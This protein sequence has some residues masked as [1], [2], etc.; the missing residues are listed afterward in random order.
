MSR[1]ILIILALCLSLSACSS[2][3]SAIDPDGDGD[4][5]GINY[6]AKSRP[7]SGKKVFIFDPNYHAWAAYDRSGKLVNTGKASGGA[8][9]CIDIKQSCHTVTGKFRILF[10]KGEDCV[11]KT[12]P[13]ETKGGA[14]MPYCMF[15][16]KGGDSIH[17]SENIPDD[18]NASHGCIRITPEAA[19]WLNLHFLDVGSTVIVRPYKGD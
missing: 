15:F 4:A 9:Y 13:L 2:L 3:P 11:S 1:I 5:K 12:Y 7:A 18:I 19:K 6:F 8:I 17:G 10:K 14:L 16:T